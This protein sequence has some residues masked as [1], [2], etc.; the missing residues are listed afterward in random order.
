MPCE[1]NITETVEPTDIKNSEP[2]KKRK[3]AMNPMLKHALSNEI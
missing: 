2:L 3:G 1:F